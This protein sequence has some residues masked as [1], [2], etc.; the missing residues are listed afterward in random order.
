MALL[1]IQPSKGMIVTGGA[2]FVR[3]AICQAIVDRGG[4][5]Y[6]TVEGNRPALYPDIEQTFAESVHRTDLPRG[7]PFRRAG[8]ACRPATRRND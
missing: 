8:P 7:F 6:F 5:N 1:K 3:T 2:I 4:A